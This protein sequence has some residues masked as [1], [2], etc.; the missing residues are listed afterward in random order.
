MKLLT[1][2]I[3]SAAVAFATQS[4]AA[5]ISVTTDSPM[6]PG[7]LTAAINALNHGDT[8]AFH[9]PP[10]A[11]EVH[12]ILTPPDGYPIITKN[13]ITVDGY[14]QG[15]ASANTAGIHAANNAQLRIVLSSTNNNGASMHYAWTNALGVPMPRGDW[16]DDEI[17][18]I[19]FIHATNAHVR[20]I[21]FQSNPW[22]TNSFQG[23]DPVGGPPTGNSPKIK[24]ICFAA[25]NPSNGG[26]K[27]ENFHVSGCW[28]GI[29]PT[30]R[31]V[32]FCNDNLYGVGTVIASPKI[33]VASYRQRDASGTP[34]FNWPGT[35]GVA[36][37]SANPRAEF[38]LWITGYGY[39]SEGLNYRMSGNWFN[40]LP[41]G[42]TGVDLSVQSPDQQEDGFLE[43]G[44]NTSNL[45][46]GTDGDGVNDADEGNIFGPLTGGGVCMDFYS[47]PRTNIVIAGN[48]FGVDINGKPWGPDPYIGAL[49]D[50]LGNS[51]TCRFGSDFNGVSDAL[52]ANVV[53]NAPLPSHST[54]GSA[55]TGATWVSMRGNTLLN[56][57]SSS[58]TTPPIGDGQ[59]PSDGQY[60]YEGFID[61]SSSTFVLIPVIG[62][63]T[64]TTTLAGTCGNPKALSAYTRLIVDLYE[65]D[66][67]TGAVPQGKKWLAAYT[68]NSTADGN[69]AVGAFSF[70][71]ASLGLTSGKQ[72]TIT[73]TYSKDANPTI[74]SVSR[75]G[76]QTTLT[77]TG[78]NGPG[79]GTTFGVWKASSVTGPYTLAA[80]AVG[81]STGGSVTFTDNNS[82]SFYRVTG[83]SATGQ[84]S[85]F[86]SPYTIP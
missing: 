39:D 84:T 37:G 85:P 28:F 26:G 2:L 22:G 55:T 8:I 52:E 20:G 15:G 19:S 64:T 36:A 29:D 80:A 11:G 4:R 47:D 66:T 24:A 16:G 3:T 10:E 78:G 12:Y 23:P 53:T 74:S 82:T 63:T 86:S 81:G 67:T 45:I 48:Y 5:T 72:V 65:A 79:P 25:V 59:S 61:D 60:V 17:A 21:C 83:P 38:N 49:V 56:T 76:N 54:P 9:I 44:R 50:S 58:G 77:I 70:N 14:T 43:V 7:S 69:A 62:N 73:V 40:V 46:I 30:T 1:A 75:V 35:L 41:D 32:A 57:T 27:C 13:N 6:G 34:N 51:S 33:C 71:I 18:I 42:T 68:D 31:L